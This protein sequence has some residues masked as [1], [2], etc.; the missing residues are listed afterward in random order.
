VAFAAWATQD[1]LNAVTRL[2]RP[3]IAMATG[4]TDP[5]ARVRMA[6]LLYLPRINDAA[7]R[8]K[9]TA[10]LRS[11]LRS[12][13]LNTEGLRLL[14]MIQ[15]KDGNGAGAAQTAEV[16][17][18]I[19][20]REAGLN[21]WFVEKAVRERNLP[22]V[23]RNLDVAMRPSV[24]VRDRLFPLLLQALS[25]DPTLT[26]PFAGYIRDNPSWLLDFIDYAITQ[27]K[28]TGPLGEAVILAHG[29]P[30]DPRYRPL[31]S[32]LLTKL[33]DHQHYGQARRMFSVM[34]DAKP[35]W[36]TSAGFDARGKDPSSFNPV[37]WQVYTSPDFTASFLREGNG[38]IT[39]ETVAYTA[40]PSLAARKLLFLPAGPHRFRVLAERTSPETADVTATWQIRCAVGR[41]A[42]TLA[43]R[44]IDKS[45]VLE[46]DVAVPGKCE[47]LMVELIVSGN[48][49]PDPGSM[50]FREFSLR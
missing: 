40:T 19:S 50:T 43:A 23:L 28:D 12:E 27:A 32:F 49:S 30:A 45:G 38:A 9:A 44:K 21:L 8:R 22:A 3:D 35:Q 29:M 6:D 31:E 20:R 15:E 14:A 34:R 24:T 17:R 4:L 7:A 47:A 41:D 2:R 10:M 46:F 16:G 42:P 11:G 33:V 18:R 37:T 5:V 1:A 26:K 48:V 36:L 13:P 39:L 25:G